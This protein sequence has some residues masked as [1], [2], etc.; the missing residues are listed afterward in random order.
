MARAER[1][2]FESFPFF[3]FAGVIFIYLNVEQ[4]MQSMKNIKMIYYGFATTI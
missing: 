3:G 4:Y 2:H 1:L